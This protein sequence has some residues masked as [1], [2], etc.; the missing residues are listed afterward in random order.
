VG[1]EVTGYNTKELRMGSNGGVFMNTVIRVRFHIFLVTNNSSD[2]LISGDNL[3]RFY[4][5]SSVLFSLESLCYKN[6]TFEI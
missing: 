3:Y 2:I 5:V 1:H 6:C 4:G